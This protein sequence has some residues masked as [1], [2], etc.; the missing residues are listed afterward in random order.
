MNKVLCKAQFLVPPTRN[1]PL[2]LVTRSGVS[3]EFHGLI[4]SGTLNC[5]PRSEL[6]GSALTFR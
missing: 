5:P 4:S 2:T 1:L 6:M 3:A